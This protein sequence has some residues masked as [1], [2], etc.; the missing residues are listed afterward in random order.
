MYFIIID[1][2]C[3]FRGLERRSSALASNLMLIFITMYRNSV[4][5]SLRCT[6]PLL[7]FYLYR[8]NFVGAAPD[9]VGRFEA[10]SAEYADTHPGAPNDTLSRYGR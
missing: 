8:A 9:G 4:P 3:H 10:L 2:F 6:H 7:T 5:K 1:I